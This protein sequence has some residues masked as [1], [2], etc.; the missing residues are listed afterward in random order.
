MARKPKQQRSKATVDA[1]IQATMMAIA[2]HGPAAITA[3]QIAE[4]AG[5]GVGSLYEYFEDK[6][7]IIHAA[8]VRFV[9]DTVAMIKPLV[10]ELVQMDIRSAIKMLLFRFRDFLEENNQ[11]YLKCARHAFTMDM[12]VYQEPVNRAL[13]D[14]FTQ[15]L[16]HHPELLKLP[17]IPTVAYFYIN[18]GV[19]TVVR[20]LCEEKP[21]QTFE[22]LTEVFGDV[23]A[24][25][26]EHKLTTMR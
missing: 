10:P 8:S 2:E 26:T 17:N 14:F 18:G 1:I 13:M 4:T 21:M 22:E 12:V 16:M 15:Y 11:L 7:A 5:I 24:S 23:L 25:Y 3:R 19:F 6:D 9:D 20:H